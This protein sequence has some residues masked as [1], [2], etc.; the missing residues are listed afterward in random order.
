MDDSL[1]LHPHGF[2]FDLAKVQYV[3]RSYRG[4]KI[5]NT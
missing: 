4:L 5:I 2:A 3:P 1:E